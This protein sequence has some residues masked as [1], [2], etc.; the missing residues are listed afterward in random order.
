MIKSKPQNFE[1]ST[2]ISTLQNRT[3]RMPK[4]TIN[5]NI[6]KNINY[7]RFNNH[8]HEEN[9]LKP[10]K[11]TKSVTDIIVKNN[12]LASSS[13]FKIDIQ[14]RLRNK[15]LNSEILSNMD[16]NC[17]RFLNLVNYTKSEKYDE[18]HLTKSNQNEHGKRISYYNIYKNFKNYEKAKSSSRA[19]GVVKS[20][21]VN[22]YKGTM[23]DYNE[24][25]VSIVMNV[26]KPTSR[27]IDAWPK[28]S[29]FAVFDG[30]GGNGCANYMKA[31][32]HHYVIK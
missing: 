14:P 19:F 29:Y 3:I 26:V 21:G 6:L 10:I 1:L 18:L 16:W 11:L 23:R 4:Y 7:K 17:K 15:K 24:D 27:I 28:V 2:D 32:L 31:N 9:S 13:K 30:H 8:L 12:L 25:R 5:S 22:T 20:F